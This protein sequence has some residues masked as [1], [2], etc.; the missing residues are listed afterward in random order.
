MGQT[1]T[2]LQD[3]LGG[4]ALVKSYLLKGTLF[5]KY[6]S[7]LQLETEKKLR[8]VKRELSILPIML[9][10]LSSPTILSILVGSYLILN[11]EITG[12]ELFIFIYLL[13]ISLGPVAKFPE[14]FINLFE[15]KGASKRV[16]QLLNH[17]K[18]NHEMKDVQISPQS[19]PIDFEHVQ[20]SYEENTPAILHDFDGKLHKGQT[21]ALVGAS[22]GGKSTVFKLLCGFYPLAE[23]Q[24]NIKLFGE[25]IKRWNPTQLR[26]NISLVTQESYLFSGTIYD[27]IA[28]GRKD[29]TMDEVIEAAKSANAHSFIMELPQGY[30]TEV[31]ERGSGL[32]GG[33]RQR[34]AIA[35]ALLKDAPI[36]LL[37]EPTSALDT[38]SEFLVQQALSSLMSERTTMVIAHRLTTIQNANEIWVMEEGRI[39]ERGNH[40]ALLAKNGLYTKL[41][42]KQFDEKSLSQR[43]E[44][45]HAVQQI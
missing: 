33:Q 23:G 24:G 22:G 26:A 13:G 5:N 17:P 42:N 6:R 38:E 11:Q 4:M 40:Q 35:R 25:S 20:F 36:L 1:N 8:M 41:Y 44:C 15:L 3:T 31:G 21:I 7:F 29:A 12:A 18:E 27:N 2:I 30:Q 19:I 9:L 39:V 28:F 45:D 34:V 32:S 37:D 14:M 10:M 16:F 43:G